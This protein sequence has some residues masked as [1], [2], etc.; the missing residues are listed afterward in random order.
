M[1][2]ITIEYSDGSTATWFVD[3]DLGDSI[4]KIENLLI[5]VAGEPDS[6]QC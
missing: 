6:I 1:H 4:Q 5:N 2:T 3:E